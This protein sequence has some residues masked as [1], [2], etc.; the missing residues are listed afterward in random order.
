M[1]KRGF[2]GST[3]GQGAFLSIVVTTALSGLLW[4]GSGARH[5]FPDISLAAVGWFALA[6]VLTVMIGRVFLYASI[7]AL[8]AIRGSTIKRLNP[9]FAV[10]L[11]VIFLDDAISANL[12]VGMILIFAS[13][14]VLVRKSLHAAPAAGEQSHTV[15]SRVRRLGYLYGPVS[16]L[17]YATGYVFRKYGLTEMPD[18][19]FG[20][21][22]GA[23]SGMTAFALMAAI[24]DNYRSDMTRSFTEF[25][26][27]L[28]LAAIASTLGQICYFVALTHITV[29]KIALI[30]S[31]E[32]F[33]TMFLSLLV[34]RDKVRLTPDVVIAAVLG[35][36]GTVWII[37]D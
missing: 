4:V 34:F 3:R 35:F 31:M 2:D 12:A 19:L 14:G 18:A 37:A 5:G 11:G 30:T 27:W 33:L 23:V 25:N 13:F 20:T 16:A 26:L 8:G 15:M 24:N 1:I 10:L 28:M 6:G 29:S 9:V 36:L 7:Q 32:V 21:L 22:V 17:A